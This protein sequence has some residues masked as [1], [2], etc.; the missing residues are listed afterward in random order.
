MTVKELINKLYHF[1]PDYQVVIYRPDNIVDHY[2]PPGEPERIY[3]G[4]RSNKGH[5]TPKKGRINSIVI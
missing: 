3:I 4:K 2:D 5:T 1:P